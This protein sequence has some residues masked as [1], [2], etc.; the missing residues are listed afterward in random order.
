MGAIIVFKVWGRCFCSF[1]ALYGGACV[2]RCKRGFTVLVPE[3][4]VNVFFNYVCWYILLLV[5]DALCTHVLVL[6]Q[7]QCCALCWH[8][9]STMV[10]LVLEYFLGRIIMSA[11]MFSKCCI[12]VQIYSWVH[13][14][15]ASTRQF[16]FNDSATSFD[17]NITT[18][19]QM[20]VFSCFC[21]LTQRLIW[22]SRDLALLRSDCYIMPLSISS[23]YANQSEQN[24]CTR[25]CVQ[26]GRC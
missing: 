11:F 6:A 13:T 23:L 22:L 3:S 12:L 19:S 10:Y 17:N 20:P 7:C 18:C 14:T 26:L 9:A 25:K 16:S 1:Y 8:G 4:V 2:S 5:S 15:I 21:L 24:A